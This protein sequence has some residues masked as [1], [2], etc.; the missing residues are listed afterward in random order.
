MCTFSSHEHDPYYSGQ[1]ILEIRTITVNDSV[2]R[3][4]P[5]SAI[6]HDLTYLPHYLRCDRNGK[7]F[8]EQAQLQ[9]PL[10]FDVVGIDGREI[11][12]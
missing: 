12:K 9:Q 1:R 11:A 7:E 4:D 10:R 5:K 2:T 6:P 8:R 3:G